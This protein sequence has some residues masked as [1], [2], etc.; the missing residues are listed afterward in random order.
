M[1]LDGGEGDDLIYGGDGNEHIFCGG[2]DD[3]TAANP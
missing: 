1:Y 2:G 3:G